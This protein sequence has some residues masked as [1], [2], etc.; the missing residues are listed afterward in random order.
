MCFCKDI[1]IVG[2]G[3][4]W[5]LIPQWVNGGNISTKD[6]KMRINLVGL[7]AAPGV[8]PG[9]SRCDV[10]SQPSAPIVLGPKQSLALPFSARQERLSLA[11]RGELPKS[12]IFGGER[13]TMTALLVD[14]ELLGFVSIQKAF[15]GTLRIPTR[16]L[17]CSIASAPKAIAQMMSATKRTSA[18]PPLF[19]TRHFNVGIR[20]ARKRG[21]GL[22]PC[23]ASSLRRFRTKVQQ[24]HIVLAAQG[25][26][27]R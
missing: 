25:S 10:I 24:L 21:P 11:S 17:E 8:N 12:S 9:F 20:R 16:T 4:K 19:A 27:G 7:D 1:S 26:P 2:D 23:A 14:K 5:N 6:M 22:N 13:L 15:W 18:F 3:Q